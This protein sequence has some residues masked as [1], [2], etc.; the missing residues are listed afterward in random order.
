MLDGVIHDAALP[1]ARCVHLF[2]LLLHG[3]APPR[4]GTVQMLLPH[5]Q[6]PRSGF[7]VRQRPTSAGK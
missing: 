7:T 6:P 3:D 2:W 5:E 1:A 4:V